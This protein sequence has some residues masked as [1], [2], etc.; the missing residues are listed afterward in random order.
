MLFFLSFDQIALSGGPCNPSEGDC[1][2]GFSRL[3]TAIMEVLQAEPDSLVLNAGDTFQGTVWYNFLRW[4]VSQHFM[5]MLP[6]D[7]HVS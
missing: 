4:N 1:I 7:A 2:G 6:H 5:N 3:Y